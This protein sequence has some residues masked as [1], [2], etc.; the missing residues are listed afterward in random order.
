M[1][2][3]GCMKEETDSVCDRQCLTS[4]QM[5]FVCYPGFSQGSSILVH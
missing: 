1:N 2:V 3:N 4:V 5:Y